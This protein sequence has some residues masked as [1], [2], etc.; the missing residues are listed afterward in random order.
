[1]KAR[2]EIVPEVLGARVAVGLEED[3]QALVSAAARG[4]QRG[5]NLDRV[6]AVVVDQR[7]A[8]DHAFDFEAAADSGEI[9]QARANQIR[10]DVQIERDGGSGRGIAHVV[11]ARRPG[12]AKL[13]EVVAAIG[14]PEAAGQPLQSA[15]RR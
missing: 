12:Q 7:D 2:A 1:M 4:F 8:A 11:N 13:A 10:R 14:Q 5:A 3:Q 15:D 6:V 9:F